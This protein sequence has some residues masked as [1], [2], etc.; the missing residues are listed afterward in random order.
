[1]VL[2]C[3]KK[4]KEQRIRHVIKNRLENT[5]EVGNEVLQYGKN[6]EIVFQTNWKQRY[7]WSFLRAHTS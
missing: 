2:K 7:R 4:S 1:M 6:W 5:S 3:D